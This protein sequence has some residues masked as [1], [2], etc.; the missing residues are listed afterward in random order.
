RIRD[1]SA[2]ERLYIPPMAAPPA[3]ALSLMHAMS[4]WST[5]RAARY[6]SGTAR[7]RAGVLSSR[8][9]AMYA[10]CRHGRAGDGSA[11]DTAWPWEPGYYRKFS[12]E[13]VGWI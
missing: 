9:R 4:P 3:S 13:A 7:P 2:P 1:A 11:P 5:V 8:P 6:P 10:S 12:A